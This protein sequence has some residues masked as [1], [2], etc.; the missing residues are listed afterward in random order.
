MSAPIGGM[1]VAVFERSQNKVRLSASDTMAALAAI[2]RNHEDATTR[3][4]SLNRPESLRA[5]RFWRDGMSRDEISIRLG[6]TLG[7]VERALDRVHGGRYDDAGDD[8]V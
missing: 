5:A 3:S 7:A 2:R 4:H 6:C 8:L 1:L